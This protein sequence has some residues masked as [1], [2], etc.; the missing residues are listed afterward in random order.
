M[1]I[2]ELV[3]NEEWE[4]PVNPNLWQRLVGKLQTQLDASGFNPK[5]YFDF[6]VGFDPV[7][8][9]ETKLREFFDNLPN[10]TQVKNKLKATVSEW[11]QQPLYGVNLYIR[12]LMIY[13]LQDMGVNP[14]SESKKRIPT[15]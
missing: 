13:K 7:P 8:L 1:R 6:G 15:L 3:E 4:P 9:D 2:N 11:N 12:N 10:T 14:F 5:K